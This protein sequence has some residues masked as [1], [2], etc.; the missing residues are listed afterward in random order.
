MDKYFRPPPSD[1]PVFDELFARIWT[2]GLGQVLD[3]HGDSQPW[4]A[5]KLEEA[6]GLQGYTINQRTIEYW[7]A[8]TTLP[9]GKNIRALA[10]IISEPADYDAWLMALIQSVQRQKKM[11]TQEKDAEHVSPPSDIEGPNEVQSKLTKGKLAKMAAIGFLAVPLISAGLYLA[12]QPQITKLKICDGAHFSVDTLTCDHH[13]EMLPKGIKK[14][15]VSFGFRNVPR[16]EVFHRIWFYDGMQFLTKESRYIEP[17]EGWTWIGN[18]DPEAPMANPMT[19]GE[20][21][22]QVRV[23]DTIEVASFTIE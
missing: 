9:G 20:Y 19:S 12:M 15:Y 21:T 13:M 11:G 2:L 6:L 5:A 17:W 14:I 4:T 8:G 3:K 18:Q 7:K 22:L 16:G 10:R 23:R 1:A